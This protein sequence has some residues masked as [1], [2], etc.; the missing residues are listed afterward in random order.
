MSRI[1]AELDLEAADTAGRTVI[2]ASSVGPTDDIMAPLGPLT[3][4]N[5][6]KIFHK[7]AEGLKA[8]GADVLWL[9]TISTPEEYKAAAE[10]FALAGLD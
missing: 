6:V 4:G 10:G 3:H 1:A 5:A 7:Q 2:V 9:E 8:G